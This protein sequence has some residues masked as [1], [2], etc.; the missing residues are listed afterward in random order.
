MA[1]MMVSIENPSLD[2]LAHY[3]IKGMKWGVRK[4]RY[5]STRV[6]K[7]RSV[8]NTQTDTKMTNTE[9]IRMLERQSK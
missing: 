2:E 9:I 8:Y 5:E 3:G 1:T 6:K 4:D 7:A